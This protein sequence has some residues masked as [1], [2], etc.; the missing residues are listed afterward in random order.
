MKQ[1]VFTFGR[2]N[3]PTRGHEKLLRAAK[4]LART[5]GADYAFFAS[6]SKDTDKNPLEPQA[7]VEFLQE[8]FPGQEFR[9]SQ[10]A[11]T[12]CRELAS[13]GYERAVF[14]VGRDRE[15]GLFN[16]LKKY[17]D[18]PDATKSIGLKE[19]D[20]Y[21]IDR[22]DGDYSATSA[23]QRVREGNFEAFCQ[24]VPKGSPE[25]LQKLYNA[26]RTG[27]GLSDG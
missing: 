20:Q 12:A 1:V 17:V 13:S 10:S 27:M 15:D 16:A 4:E 21:V 7:K 5:V 24:I 14:V 19:I 23:R 22:E 18:H 8:F 26:V 3:P 9:V 6:L 2:M 11:F 25:L